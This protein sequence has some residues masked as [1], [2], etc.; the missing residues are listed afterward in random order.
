VLS[1]LVPVSDDLPGF[2]AGMSDDL[3]RLFA[4]VS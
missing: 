1:A 4:R 3:L 2:L